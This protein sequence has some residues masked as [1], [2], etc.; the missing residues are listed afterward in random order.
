M[1]AVTYPD[2][3]VIDL[4]DENV[5]PVRELF[6]AE[7]LA[8]KFNVKWTP[9]L[10]ILDVDGKEHYRST[11]FLPPEELMPLILLARGKSHFDR[12]EFEQAMRLLD[13]VLD[14]Y[15]QSYWAPEAVYYRAVSRY[16]ST[17]NP[18]PLKKGYEEL[19]ADYPSSMWTK[20]AAPYRLLET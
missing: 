9:L 1:D 18:E 19:Q 10:V 4:I 7:P 8:T 20:K 5:V 16:K 17:H 12:G 14:E 2:K 13:K 3:G 11:G 6:D 15:G